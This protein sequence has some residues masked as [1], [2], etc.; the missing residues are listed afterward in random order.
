MELSKRAIEQTLVTERKKLEG[1]FTAWLRKAPTDVYD[2]LNDSVAESL[3]E[4]RDYRSPYRLS[5]DRHRTF[6]LDLTF[7]PGIQSEEE[8]LKLL[9]RSFIPPEA[10][11]VADSVQ[12]HLALGNST[13]LFV[14]VHFTF[15][16][17]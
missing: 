17:G 10:T 15:C 5:K 12:N 1:H 8:S 2:P 9:Q 3:E 6:R 16:L 11:I 7:L 14:A 13:I 4:M